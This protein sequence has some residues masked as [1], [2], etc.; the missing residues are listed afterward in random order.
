M[1]K[2]SVLVVMIAA[3]TLLAGCDGARKALT[4]TKA[5]PDEF[6]VYT[7]APLT[8]PPDYGLRPPADGKTEDTKAVNTRD[9]ARRVLLGSAND[10]KQ[11]IQ[12]STPGTSALLAMAGVEHAEPN[13]RDIVERETSAYAK[14]NVRFM[15]KLM[16]GDKANGTGT[17]VDPL[18]ES[19]RIQ[20]NQALGKPITEGDTPMIDTKPES[21]LGGII[22]GW[23][24]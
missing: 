17:V 15:E 13:I 18:N 12:A 7:R 1:K 5:G 24:N 2:T 8:M 19:K 10:Q 6:T 22:K 20:E 4:Q 16:Y 3:A 21:G 9:K 14:E 11:P 23:F